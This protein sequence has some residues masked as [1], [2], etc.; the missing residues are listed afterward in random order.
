MFTIR[1]FA[2]EDLE[3]VVGLET[4]TPE[5]P[6]WQPAAYESFLLP[7]PSENVRHA[8]WVALEGGHLQGFAA[9][10]LVLDICDLESI[11]VEE[12]ARRHGIGKALLDTVNE[13]ALFHGAGRI[14]LEVRAGNEKA[15]RFYEKAGLF[16]EGLR[17]A[18]YCAPEEDAVLM[19]KNLEQN[20][21]PV[22]N[23]PRKSD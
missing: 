15:I 22:E 6:H 11:I 4:P 9:A 13:W 16:K 21:P 3:Q 8:A 2:R 7:P 12:S 5:A 17:A 18:Y 10:R 14:E 1:P 19:A 23:F 20:Q